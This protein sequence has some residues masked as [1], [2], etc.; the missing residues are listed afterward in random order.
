[1]KNERQANLYFKYPRLTVLQSMTPQERMKFIN[2]KFQSDYKD[3]TKVLG[4]HPFE[5]IGTMRKPRGI[6]VN[7]DARSISSLLKLNFID[8]SLSTGITIARKAAG[9]EQSYFCFKTIF[10]IQIEGHTK[11]LQTYEERFVLVK[12]TSWD[13]AEAKVIKQFKDKEEPYLNGYGEMVRWKFE[14][15]EESYYTSVETEDGF[16]T[17]V[18]IFSKLKAR[19]LKKENIWRPNKTR[20]K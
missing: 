14:S 16:H 13:K 19:R 8:K 11:G 7:R 10:Q 9:I 4:D 5:I 15:I 2:R 6:K 1:M 17:P 3:I 12:A 20:K 18:E